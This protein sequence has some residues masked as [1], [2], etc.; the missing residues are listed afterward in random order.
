MHKE[1]V[2]ISWS[3][4]KDSALALYRIIKSEKYEIFCLLTTI[5]QDFNRVTM[6]G[7]R[8]ELIRKQAESLGFELKEVFIPSYAKNEIYEEKMREANLEL[9]SKG[10][11]KHVFGDIFLE[12]VRKYR[13]DNLRKLNLEGIW[14]LW[15]EDTRKLA[16]EFINLGFKAIICSIDGNILD[17]SFV[18]REFDD[19]FLSDL[20]NNVD[21]CGE[22]GEFHSFVYDGP[23]FKNKVEFKIGEKVF[24]DNRFYFIDLFL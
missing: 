14:P 18:G 9:L 11:R 19:D 16:K 3:G 12:D 2:V 15:G 7:V 13:E 1:K 17:S 21:P 8:R 23:I 22:R 10:I 20:P 4:G 5:T 6:H 24:R